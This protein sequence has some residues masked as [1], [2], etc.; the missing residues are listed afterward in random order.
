MLYTK[1]LMPYFNVYEQMNNLCIWL[2][3]F[4][5]KYYFYIHMYHIMVLFDVT[6]NAIPMFIKLSEN[7]FFCSL[8]ETFIC[9]K[10]YKLKGIGITVCLLCIFVKNLFDR[11]LRML[12][13]L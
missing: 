7:K 13:I 9:A 10:Y 5:H 11:R 3:F 1:E 12:T 2:I 8:I 4:S 6:V